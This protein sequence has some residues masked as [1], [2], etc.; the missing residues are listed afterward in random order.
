M[1]F[2]KIR[3]FDGE[4]YL[5]LQGVPEKMFLSVKGT[6]LAKEHFF[7]DTWYKYRLYSTIKFYSLGKT[8]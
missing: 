4:G 7:W 8:Q 6:L 2:F 5:A 1:G 3:I